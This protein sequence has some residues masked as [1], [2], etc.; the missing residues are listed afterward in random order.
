MWALRLTTCIT[1]NTRWVKFCDVKI[2]RVSQIF[3][4]LRKLHIGIANSTRW[5]RFHY[6]GIIQWKHFSN[7]Y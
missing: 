2:A 7:V 4:V 3:S 5:V 6:A 1:I